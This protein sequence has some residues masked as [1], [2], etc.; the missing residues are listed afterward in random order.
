MFYHLDVT[1]LKLIK[2]PV[3]KKLSVALAA[4]LSSYLRKLMVK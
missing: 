4:G 2:L 1:A 3:S